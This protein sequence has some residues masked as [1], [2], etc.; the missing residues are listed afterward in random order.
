MLIQSKNKNEK[1]VLGLLSYTFDG[2]VSS[3]KQRALLEEY[4]ESDEVE[5]YLFKENETDN[6][7]G[8]MVIEISKLNTQALVS[9]ITIEKIALIP[10]YRDEGV[11]YQ[12]YVELRELYPNASIQG[13]I[14]MSEIVKNW[15]IK[16]RENLENI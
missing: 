2:E 10:S 13:S 8:V 14:L 4:R 1:I 7:I 12:M 9:A 11:G 16:Y 15:S 5:I 3:S 6:F